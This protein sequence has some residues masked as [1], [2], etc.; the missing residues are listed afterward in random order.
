MDGRVEVIEA[1]V[2]SVS[3]REWCHR[4]LAAAGLVQ[5]VAGL[6]GLTGRGGGG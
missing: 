5:H 1:V 4:R 3:S 6:T 2:G